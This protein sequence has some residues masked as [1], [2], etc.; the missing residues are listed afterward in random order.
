[1]VAKLVIFFHS[2]PV[3]NPGSVTVFPAPECF[4]TDNGFRYA[5]LLSHLEKPRIADT[6]LFKNFLGR[7]KFLDGLGL[8]FLPLDIFRWVLKHL[9]NAGPADESLAFQAYA[10]YQTLCKT[11]VHGGL[12]N[13]Q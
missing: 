12:A 7:I 6:E 5:P 9:V 3:Q 8:L 13:P 2:Q 1:M 10:R 11:A 4:A